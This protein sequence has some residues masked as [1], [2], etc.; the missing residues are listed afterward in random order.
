MKDI[1]KK[2]GKMDMALI[3]RKMDLA[4]LENGEMIKGM[5]M[6]KKDGQMEQN[7]KAIISLASKMEKVLI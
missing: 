4:M 3:K 5:A 1:F 2:G 7:I 6:A